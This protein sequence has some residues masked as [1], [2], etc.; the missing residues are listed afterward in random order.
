MTYESEVLIL[1]IIFCKSYKKLPQLCKKCLNFMFFAILGRSFLFFFVFISR[2]F[3]EGGLWGHK[4]FYFMEG[5][6]ERN[7]I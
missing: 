2:E 4:N 3:F 7:K 1:T 6:L 5:E